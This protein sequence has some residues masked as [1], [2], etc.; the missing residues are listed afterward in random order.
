MTEQ[1]QPADWPR[2]EAR[3]HADGTA[4][5]LIGGKT[6]QIAAGSIDAARPQ[7]IALVARHAAQLGRPLRAVTNDPD[8]Q[9][10]L[11]IH[12]D[13]T[14][15]NDPTAPSRP[16]PPNQNPPEPA[17]R[18]P[19][20]DRTEPIPQLET[21]LQPQAFQQTGPYASPSAPSV[22]SPIQLASTSP[23]PQAPVMPAKPQSEVLGTVPPPAIATTAAPVHQPAPEPRQSFLVQEQTEEP[24]T[25]GWRGVVARLGLRV[26]PNETERA[27]R[28]DVQAVSQH[29]PGPRTI[30][31]VNAKGGAGKTPTT[32]LLA[33]VFARYGGA[34]VLTWDNNQTRGTLG[35][36]TEQ[37]PHDATV[38]ELLPQVERL[39]GT[40]AQSADLAHFVHHQT[41][42]RFDVLRSK[43]TALSADQRV[44]ASDV[45]AIHQVASK[46]YRLI[47]VDS[48]NDESDPMWLRMI[49]HTDQLVVATTT[50]DDHA[51]AGALLLE[52]LTS[53]DQH[54]ADLASQAV[55]VVTQADPRASRS[56]IERVVNGY[57]D[58]AREARTIPYDP[59]MVD[60]VLRYGSLRPVTR[61]AWLGAAAAVARGL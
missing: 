38:L 60:G 45:D 36:R 12:A 39:L 21:E 31:I 49:D 30:A 2:V 50:R 51:E 56:D 32:V 55:V 42:D 1:P 57:R 35:W 17:P 6:H 13:G 18:E 25:Q 43:P 5:V 8:G 33:A 15:E 10:P 59:A 41:R 14:V 46:Y 16:N 3:I 22:D 20:A 19:S 24:A 27:E 52:A 4:D 23:Q 53:R 29:W 26:G 48:G 58:L 44:D 47:F 7:V 54:G 40:G 9:W 37:G 28:A 34:G 61:R 11:I